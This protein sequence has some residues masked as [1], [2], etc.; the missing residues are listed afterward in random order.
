[1]VF[2]FAATAAIPVSATAQTDVDLVLNLADAPDPIPAGGVITYS[3][4]VSNAALPLAT[5]VQFTLIVPGNAFYQG[6]TG[7]SV[8]CFG[9]AVGASGAG[10][11][12]LYPAESGVF[13][14]CGFSL[15][16]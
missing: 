7:A 13:G 1:M 10:N 14:E 12:D 3:A 9:M 4:S 16:I 11:R 5:G 2:A 6:F 8:T 15:W